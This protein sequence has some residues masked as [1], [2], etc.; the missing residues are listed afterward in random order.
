MVV[1]RVDVAGNMADDLAAD[2]LGDASA[3]HLGD[4]IAAP[5][6]DVHLR[7]DLLGMVVVVVRPAMPVVMGRRP[8]LVYSQ[9]T[10]EKTSQCR[11][12][13]KAE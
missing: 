5:G 11:T 10:E 13:E 9:L 1:P 3:R 4:D 2:L 6:V 12:R 8:G 7:P